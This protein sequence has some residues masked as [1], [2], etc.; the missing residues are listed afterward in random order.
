MLWNLHS[1]NGNSFPCLYLL[2]DMKKLGS[3]IESL[4][5]P[6]ELQDFQLSS[7]SFASLPGFGLCTGSFTAS[8]LLGHQIQCQLKKQATENNIKDGR[9]EK[10]ERLKRSILIIPITV[11]QIHLLNIWII[12]LISPI[13]NGFIFF[14]CGYFAPRNLRT[15]SANIESFANY[16]FHFIEKGIRK[17]LS[18]LALKGFKYLWS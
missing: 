16:I 13:V 14:S 11:S 3:G 6:S 8:V 1:N 9:I 10:S 5:Y 2:W 15:F 18:S 17:W 12:L 4:V 7:K